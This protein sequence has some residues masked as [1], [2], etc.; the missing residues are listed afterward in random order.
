MTHD[1]YIRSPLFWLGLGL[2]IVCVLVFEPAIQTAW[3]VPFIT[4]ILDQ[5]S[6]TPW[7]SFLARFNDA[8]A[9]PYGPAMVLV[10]LP[11]V[12]AGWLAARM[13]GLSVLV[14]IGFKISLLVADFGVFKVLNKM[15]PDHQYNIILF[16]WL[17]PIILFVT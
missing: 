14:A 13:T 11:F 3:F 10:H 15:F 17:S 12:F 16:Y 5:P 8:A 9:F 1:G 2:R 7:G 6:L 4:S